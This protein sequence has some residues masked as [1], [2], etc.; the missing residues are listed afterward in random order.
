MRLVEKIHKIKDIIM[1]KMEMKKPEERKEQERQTLINSFDSYMD[2]RFGRNDFQACMEVYKRSPSV[3]FAVSTIAAIASSVEWFLRPIKDDA[4]IENK[5]KLE[6]FFK[7]PNNE[8]PFCSLI[9]NTV[10]RL[11][12]VSEAFWEMV[13]DENGEYQSI[14]YIFGEVDPIIEKNKIVGY[15][16]KGSNQILSPERVLYFR[17][18]DPLTFR[19]NSSLYSLDALIAAEMLNWKHNLENFRTKFHAGDVIYIP[20][21]TSTEEYIRNREEIYAQYEKRNRKVMVLERDRDDGVQVDRARLEPLEG[22]Y[23]KLLEQNSETIR[24]YLGLFEGQG[25]ESEFAN[26]DLYQLEVKP[27]LK[28]IEWTINLFITTRMKILDWEF[29]FKPYSPSLRAVARIV[30][31]L[32]KMGAITG[33][34][35]RELAG[36]EPDETEPKLNE[37]IVTGIG[38]GE[39][40][41]EGSKEV[42]KVEK[43]AGDIDKKLAEFR[44]KFWKGISKLEKQYK[45]DI[46][47][48][49]NSVK[50]KVRSKLEKVMVGKLAQGK[51]TPEEIEKILESIPDNLI[52]HDLVDLQVDG[53]L[54]GNANASK[55][56]KIGRVFKVIPEKEMNKIKKRA[57]EVSEDTMR[58]LK[59]GGL[60]GQK[61]LKQVLIDAMMEDLNLKETV[62]RVNELFEDWE[63]F[64]SERIVRTE[65][66]RVYNEGRIDTYAEEGIKKVRVELGPAPCEDCIRDSEM[67]E[68]L[69]S[70]IEYINSR[71]PNDM[72]IIVPVEV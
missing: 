59:Y 45:R 22:D 16:Q 54:Q 60:E 67:V 18:P 50:R 3:H 55:E 5:R 42:E 13:Q 11:K 30:Q 62:R 14:Y 48:V 68:D 2:L 23:L 46:A 12:I 51:L 33:N 15:R 27:I 24:T 56:L 70:A 26:I 6:L 17:F 34:Q 10:A 28:I 38:I 35:A 41:K 21:S 63:E 61:Y 66:Q 43:E 9:F 65:L 31:I 72:C 39:M 29:H 52:S 57:I 7:F 25:K 53:Y 37:Y 32:A 58:R 64:K 20:R 19:G 49:F 36:L 69:D 40:Q 44:E 47:S 1:D 8:E 71:H 4:S